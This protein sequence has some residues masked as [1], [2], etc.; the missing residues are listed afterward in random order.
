M[1]HR[2]LPGGLRMAA[3]INLADACGPA[4]WQP[5]L[6][7]TTSRSNCEAPLSWLHRYG[8]L[9]VREERRTVELAQF[10]LCDG[11]CRL[12]L[13]RDPGES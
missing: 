2:N 9:R 13:L 12:P 3:L 11:E 8:R 7:R 1:S 5:V 4:N 6:S 10:L